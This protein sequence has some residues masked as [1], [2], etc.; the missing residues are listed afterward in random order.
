MTVWVHLDNSQLECVYM[1]I[2]CTHYH[3]SMCTYTHMQSGTPYSL[4]LALWLWFSVYTVMIFRARVHTLLLW[5]TS[6]DTTDSM[7]YLLVDTFVVCCCMCSCT[8]HKD[9]YRK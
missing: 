6:D 2:V 9:V 5:Y 1:C 3:L 8:R 4:T 7:L